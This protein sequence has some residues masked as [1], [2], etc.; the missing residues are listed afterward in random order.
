M[1][2]LRGPLVEALRS[3]ASQWKADGSPF[4]AV[5]TE[6]IADDIEVGGP[7]WTVLSSHAS[8]AGLVVGMTGRA[9]ITGRP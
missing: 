9:P 1:D 7:T 8:R 2:D 6:R 4:Y 5:L 3:N